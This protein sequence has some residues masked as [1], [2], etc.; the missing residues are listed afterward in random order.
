MRIVSRRLIFAQAGALALTGCVTAGG[1]VASDVGVIALH[2]KRGSPL[3]RAADGMR[4]A[5][6][7]AGALEV[8]EMP[9][10]ANRYMGSSV[11]GGHD[12]IAGIAQRL[13]A[14]GIRRLVIAGHSLGGNMAL[15]YA[16]ERGGVDAVVMLA[17]GHLPGS[18]P[19][20]P[21]NPI[22]MSLVEARGMVA[23]GR[24]SELGTFADNVLGQWVRISA[25]AED[26]IS[27][28][29]PRGA[30]NM[31]VTAARLSPSIPVLMVVGT[32]DRTWL[33]ELRETLFP[34]LPANPR[35]CA[36]VVRADHDG[37]PQVASTQVREWMREVMT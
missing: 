32:G 10:S 11:Q 12:Q 4:A 21:D 30:A 25:R 14:R 1:G 6:F 15:S 28:W 29:D 7:D 37:V 35:N 33:Q 26:Y 9:W 5:F 3:G 2:G 27:W 13:R 17:P 34:L 24:G 19:D 20:R 36:L 18:V 16:A 8:P 22:V 31:V 23:A